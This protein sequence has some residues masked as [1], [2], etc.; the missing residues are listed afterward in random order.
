MNALCGRN[1]GLTM[2]SKWLIAVGI[3]FSSLAFQI[4]VFKGS[5][6]RMLPF[7]KCLYCIHTNKAFR[8][9]YSTPSRSRDEM[10]ALSLG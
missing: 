2:S 4:K 3:V 10:S 6:L 5:V 9:V 1:A 8:V 7:C